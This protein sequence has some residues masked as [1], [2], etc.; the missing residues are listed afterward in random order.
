MT[1]EEFQESLKNVSNEVLIDQC[2][3]AVSEMCKNGMKAFTMCV[4]PRL[5]D[6]DIILSE[7][8]RRFKNTV[9]NKSE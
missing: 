5:T 3:K 4:P 7:L 2:D 6:T 9:D 1:H 8:I